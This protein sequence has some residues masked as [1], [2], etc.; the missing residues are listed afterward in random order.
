MQIILQATGSGKTSLLSALSGRLRLE[1]GDIHLNGE[2]LCKALRRSKIGY[3]L[4]HDVFFTDL[5]LKET[6]VVSLQFI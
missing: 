2:T 1:S 5:T 3:V 4:Q 6:L